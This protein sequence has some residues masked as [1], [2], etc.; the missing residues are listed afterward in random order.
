MMKPSPED[1]LS[2]VTDAYSSNLE[3]ATTLLV[4]IPESNS[5]ITSFT[6]LLSE[7]FKNYTLYHAPSFVL[8]FVPLYTH[9]VMYIPFSTMIY[10]PGTSLPQI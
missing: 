4:S 8:F 5:S 10:P 2:L 7:I 6:Y 3:I 9:S 1:S